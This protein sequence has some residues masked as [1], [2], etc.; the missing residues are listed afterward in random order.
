MWRFVRKG[1]AVEEESTSIC[2]IQKRK[3]GPAV[4]SLRDEMREPQKMHKRPYNAGASPL[5]N[6]VGVV[7]T[8]L[9]DTLTWCAASHR[10]W[11]RRMSKGRRAVEQAWW[12]SKNDVWSH[13]QECSR[14]WGTCARSYGGLCRWGQRS[15]RYSDAMRPGPAGIP[16]FPLRGERSERAGGCQKPTRSADPKQGSR[17]RCTSGHTL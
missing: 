2:A 1:R 17:A 3:D 5:P 6:P 13:V 14:A 12:S 15:Q 11:R 4:V 8:S 10:R 16:P 9:C 7:R